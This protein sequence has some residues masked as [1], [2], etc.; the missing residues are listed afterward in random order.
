MPARSGRGKTPRSV[1]SAVIN[2]AGVTS[3]AGL[4]TETPGGA[5]RTPETSVTSSAE[6]SSIGISLP[7][8]NR[9]Q[10]AEGV[11][12]ILFSRLACELCQ[13]DLR[14]GR[15]KLSDELSLGSGLIV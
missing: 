7:C 10:L 5:E 13:I 9:P 2:A 6:R 15:T 11:G 14:S 3:N 1:I 12:T 8:A 4:R